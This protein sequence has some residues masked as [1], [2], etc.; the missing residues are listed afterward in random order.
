M[1]WDGDRNR[2][3]IAA[4]DA[5]TRKRAYVNDLRSDL[6]SLPDQRLANVASA[7]GADDHY[8]SRGAAADAIAER[9][10]ALDDASF[11]RLKRAVKEERFG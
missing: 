11:V 1:S 3:R 4:I 9:A 8:P 7:I 2:H 6:D 10:A 5:S